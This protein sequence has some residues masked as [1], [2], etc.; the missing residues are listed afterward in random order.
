MPG[1]NA[2]LVL[3]LVGVTGVALAACSAGTP[4]ATTVPAA[5]PA[6]APTA[7]AAAVAKPAASPA[8]APAPAP[9]QPQATGAGPAD[10]S[11]DQLTLAQEF[12]RMV[13]YT[14]DISVLVPDLTKLPDQLGQLAQ[15]Q[16]G[17]VAGVETKI[18][19][20][21]P[22]VIVRLKVPPERYAATMSGIRDLAVDVRSEKAT[23]QDVTEE[24]SDAQTQIASLEA[25]HAQ[26]LELMK[27]TG[28]VEELLKVQQQAAQVKLQI[29]RLKGRATALERLSALATIGVSA[30]PAAVVIERDYT[31]AL[32]A[33]RQAQSQQA[34]LLAQLKRVRT[35]EEESALRDK[36][37]QAD[38][39]S[40]RARSR[41]AA[42]EQLAGRIKLEL[43]KPDNVPVVASTDE[44]L[45]AE[46]LQTRVDLR[47][48]QSDQQRLT[49]ELETGTRDASAARLQ[50]A[51]LRTNNLSIKLRQLQER[52]GQ[53]GIA[54]PAI[55]P[56]EESALAG[57]G[58]PSF[59]PMLELRR[60]W[61]T[62]VNLLVQLG[63]LLIAV[64]WLLLPI[65]LAVVL[66]TRTYRRERSSQTRA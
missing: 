43:P 13:I 27:R 12:S 23:T 19:E 25:T 40:D 37:G 22:S 59:D 34:G 36:L 1:W 50:E 46:Y 65:G 9:A 66:A 21:V 17:Y 33:L 6:A 5:A 35:P 62:S 64:W 56:Q 52:A 42:L 18:D 16:G 60:G 31:Q 15:L 14:T 32:A 10:T 29:D 28:S 51:I 48:A 38:L 55:S 3:V 39:V 4:A 45:P 24:Y 47:R 11:T 54:L 44:A 53:A 61:T 2:R 7:A 58:G 63:S 20:A 26:L 30:Q 41:V 49:T 57:V 8:A